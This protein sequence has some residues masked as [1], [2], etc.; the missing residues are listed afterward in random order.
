MKK[1]KILIW[2]YYGAQNFG[3]D[4]IFNVL[5]K[6]LK[7]L[8]EKYDIYYSV[9][10][11]KSAY[12]INATPI[13]FFGKKNSFKPLN[14][15]LNILQLYG[16]ILKM[17][18]VIIGGG[19]QYFEIEGRKPISIFLKEVA[20]KLCK[21][22]GNP[23]IN[24][25]VGIGNIHSKLGKRSIKNLFN[26]ASYS[27][28]RDQNSYDTLMKLGVKPENVILGK[29][30][31][32]YDHKISNQSNN[33][34][35]EKKVGINLFDF[36]N[37][38]ENNPEKDEKYK[39][40]LTLFLKHLSSNNYQINLFA[41]QKEAGGRDFEFLKGISN[42]VNHHFYYYEDNMSLFMN[43]VSNM[44]INVGMRYHLSVISLQA[45]I[46]V[47]GLNYQPKVKREFKL[48]KLEN[49]VLEMD[50]ILEGKL[51]DLFDHVDNNIIPLKK[52]LDI[53]LK[54]VMGQVN[55]STLKK[56]TETVLNG[57]R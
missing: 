29:D 12:N 57:N 30:L 48:F 38:I 37:Y 51:I 33:D 17:D 10:S 15:I 23:F 9:T 1:K 11:L 54:E 24:A 25:G 4:L 7:P 45:G 6:E 49:L 14:F 55:A 50:E 40:N 22:K 20:R 31:S 13:D 56:V 5:F 44:D 18:A 27:F 2:G 35:T 47:I 32:Y 19:T 21:L 36:Y 52:Q 34:P 3:D 28:V 41:L 42:Q 39:C 46:P 8:Q 53:S 16:A 26:K 43:K